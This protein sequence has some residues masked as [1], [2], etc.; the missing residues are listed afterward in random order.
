MPLD[1]VDFVT[2]EIF[3]EYVARAVQ[4]ATQST[5]SQLQTLAKY[6][7]LMKSPCEFNMIAL[8][9]FRM[10]CRG[11]KLKEWKQRER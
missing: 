8:I 2:D 7:M 1:S 6:L 3:F 11:M 9:V 5:S 4:S 10:L